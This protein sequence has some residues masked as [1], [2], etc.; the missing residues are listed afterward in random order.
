MSNRRH[1]EELRDMLSRLKQEAAF[2]YR[3]GNLA[4]LDDFFNNLSLDDKKR[5]IYLALTEGD[6]DIQNV[7]NYFLKKLSPVPRNLKELLAQMSS[8]DKGEL[9]EL[10]EDKLS[11]PKSLTAIDEQRITAELRKACDRI[12]F[13]E[14]EEAFWILIPKDPAKDGF[15]IEAVG[16]KDE[17]SVRLRFP[18]EV[19]YDPEKEEKY[20][21]LTTMRN[22]MWVLH[23]HNHP[24]LPGHNSLCEPSDE[25]LGFALEWNSVRPEL[26][27][28]LKFFVIKENMAVE[29]S[30]PQG[31][32]RRWI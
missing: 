30:L 19:M 4:S 16:G 17:T 14:V 28:R 24:K 15:W 8:E 1:I 9:A 13:L 6:K 5:L 2:L 31:G 23:V 32:T 26:A 7:A 29:Y 20:D 27:K 22:A 3:Y 12:G 18:S 21:L 25:D 10:M 11:G